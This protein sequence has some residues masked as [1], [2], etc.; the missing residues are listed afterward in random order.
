[1]ALIKMNRTF[2]LLKRSA[3]PDCLN[4]EGVCHVQDH[5][6]RRSTIIAP[7]VWLAEFLSDVNEH[8]AVKQLARSEFYSTALSDTIDVVWEYHTWRQAMVGVVCER[9][10]SP[11]AVH[12]CANQAQLQR[13][14]HAAQRGVRP[15]LKIACDEMSCSV[16]CT[17]A[18]ASAKLSD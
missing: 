1:M 4:L 6:E 7:A 11:L 13:P 9:C 2:L 15:T 3:T 14:L 17:C 16:F 8:F 12:L 5:S 10:L 18:Y